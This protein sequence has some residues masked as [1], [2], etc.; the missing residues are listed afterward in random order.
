MA[1]AAKQYA[2]GFHYDHRCGV[3][4]LGTNAPREVVSKLLQ[5][6][7]GMIDYQYGETRLT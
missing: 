7:P 6:Y 3:I 1:P 5:D 2:Y 4:H